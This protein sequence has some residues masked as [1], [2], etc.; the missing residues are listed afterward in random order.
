[1]KLQLTAIIT[2][3]LLAGCTTTTSAPVVTTPAPLS[4]FNMTCDQAQ[5]KLVELE[6]KRKLGNIPFFVGA[7]LSPSLPTYAEI[8]PYD[9]KVRDCMVY[10]EK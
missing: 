8:A 3:A 2:A 1:L 4:V 5:A 9:N 6:K 10:G 7:I